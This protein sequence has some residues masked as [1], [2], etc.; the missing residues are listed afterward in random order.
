MDNNNFY[1]LD[2]LVEFGMSLAVAQQ[3]MGVMNHTLNNMQVPNAGISVGY[4]KPGYYATIND[5]IT[6]PLNDSELQSL[7][8]SGQI[9]DETFVW[10]E[11]TNGWKQAKDVPEVYKYIL[12]KPGKS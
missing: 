6:G 1:S 8:N 4:K 5:H 3:M 12:L 2:K 7:I 9:T 10:K 11:G